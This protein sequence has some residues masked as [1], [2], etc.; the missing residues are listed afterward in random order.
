MTPA[1]TAQMRD[2]LIEH[3][4]GPQLY[5]IS[6]NNRINRVRGA[7]TLGYL[8]PDRISYPRNTSLTDKGR[9]ALCKALADWADAIVLARKMARER[10]DSRML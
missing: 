3:I 1:I 2:L 10:A 7:I 9:A 4:D 6:Q 8:V 5:R